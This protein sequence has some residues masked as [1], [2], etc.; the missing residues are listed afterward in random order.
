MKTNTVL[1]ITARMS[2][3]K[4]L[5][6]EPRDINIVN[7]KTSRTREYKAKGSCMPQNVKMR[8]HTYLLLAGLRL[9]VKLWDF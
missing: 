1:Y 9:M 7:Y 5:H 4:Q 3:P 6:M 8:L 2:H